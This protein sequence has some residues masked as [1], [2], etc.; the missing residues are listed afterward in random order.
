MAEEEMTAL[1]GNLEPELQLLVELLGSFEE[2]PERDIEDFA[3]AEVTFEDPLRA[4][5]LASSLSS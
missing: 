2:D 3:R 5:R 4:T 1:A